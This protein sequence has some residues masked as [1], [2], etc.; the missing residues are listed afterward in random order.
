[1]KNYQKHTKNTIKKWQKMNY[2]QKILMFNEHV[3]K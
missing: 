3:K 2:L 1:M